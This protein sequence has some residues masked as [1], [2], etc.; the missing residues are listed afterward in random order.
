MGE[1][2]Q[3]RPHRRVPMPDPIKDKF[4]IVS[5]KDAAD[6]DHTHEIHGHLDTVTIDGLIHHRLD[7]MNFAGWIVEPNTRTKTD[8]LFVRQRFRADKFER[9]KKMRKHPHSLKE[10]KAVSLVE[11][12][13]I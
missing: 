11:Q 9:W 13:L 3:E 5:R 8:D 7:L 10:F 1:D 4:G 2:V 12:L 6:A